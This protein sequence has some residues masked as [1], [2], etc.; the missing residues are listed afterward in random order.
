MNGNT[1]NPL[2]DKTVLIIDDEQIV[3]DVI[4]EVI[5]PL[6][7]RL[8]TAGDGIDAL[9]K[10][11]ASDYD[12]I[13]LDI[14]LPKMSGMEIFKLIEDYKPHLVKNIIFITGDIETVDIRNHIR[15]SGCRVLDKPFMIKELFNVMTCCEHLA[16][17]ISKA[18]L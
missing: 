8:D 18:P 3:V 15:K 1:Y 13:L 2:H 6:V 11:L 10:A 16:G 17:A 12:Y 5:G 7:K 4:K 14:M 9:A